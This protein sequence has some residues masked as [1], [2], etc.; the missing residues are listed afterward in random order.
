MNA[1]LTPLREVASQATARVRGFGTFTNFAADQLDFLQRLAASS[2]DVA[3]FEMLARSFVLVRHPDD[4]ELI[5]V[6]H[7]KCVGRDEY[8]RVLKRALGLGLLTSEGDLWKRQRHLMAQAFVPKRIASY[9]EVMVQVGEASLARFRD[10]D[11]VELHRETSRLAAEVVSEVLFG[12]GITPDEIAMVGESLEVLNDFFANSPESILSIPKWVPTPRNVR[13]N[14]AMARV[15]ELIFRIVRE[16]RAAVPRE[17]FLGTLLA[18]QDD[19]GVRMS[20]AQLRDEA[21]TLFLAGH[22]TTALALAYTLH[23][24]A[25]HPEVERLL[26]AELE[27]V[28]GPRAPTVADVKA[29][30]YLECVLKESMRLFPP[31]WTMGREV[32]EPFEVRGH[33]LR[34]GEQILISQWVMH[35]DERWFPDPE[36]FDP[37]RF[38]PARA[39][40]IPKYAYLPFGAGPRVCIGSHFAMLEATLLLA[41]IVRRFHVELLPGQRLDFAPSVTLRPKGQGLR[42]RLRERQTA[43]G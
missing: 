38:S 41:L 35:H 33:T 11:E 39:K 31:A 25:R 5:L 13:M 7:A 28:L 2:G 14:R 40:S 10:G 27:A 20:D 34:K 12:A 4:V 6:K 37:E 36:A 43:R 3:R 1:L 16:R 19:A 30:P 23:L 18:A 17:D 42:V 29:L 22:E 9:A 15:D 8:V 32:L 26:L 24:L 21:V